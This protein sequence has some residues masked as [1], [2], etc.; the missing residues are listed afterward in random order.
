MWRKLALT[1]H[2]TSSVGWLGSVVAFLALA[3]VGVRSSSDNYIRS[4]YVAMELVGWLVIVPFSAASLITGLVQSFGTNWGLFR[5]YWVVAKL[6]I[7]VGASLLLLLHMQ[8]V[9]A[10]AHAAADGSLHIEHLRDPRT[11][12]IADAGAATV[13]LLIAIALSV[14]KPRGHT[15]FA[16][17]QSDEALMITDRATPMAYAFWIAVTLL[18]LAFVIRHISGGM[19]RHS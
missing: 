19:P 5:H 1:A 7:T 17:P 18:I 13:V 15:P 14:Y 12:L 6:L 8:V 16:R 3:I 11:Q 2:I 4:A 9:N 10:V